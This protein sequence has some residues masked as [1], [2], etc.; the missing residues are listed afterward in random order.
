LIIQM[1]GEE[2]VLWSSS[3]ILPQTPV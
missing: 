3:S 1:F 2:Y